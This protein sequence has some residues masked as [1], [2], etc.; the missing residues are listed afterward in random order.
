MV[1]AAGKLHDLASVPMVGRSEVAALA[2]DANRK[3][4]VIVSLG[5]RGVRPGRAGALKLASTAFR[6]T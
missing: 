1:D 2:T 3:H 6:R 4:G 5:E